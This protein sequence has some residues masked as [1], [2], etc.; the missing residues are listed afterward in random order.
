MSA[1]ITP[2]PTEAQ[3]PDNTKNWRG[4]GLTAYYQFSNKDDTIANQKNAVIHWAHHTPEMWAAFV[5]DA[6]NRLAGDIVHQARSEIRSRLK[7]KNHSRRVFIQA[8]GTQAGTPAILEELDSPVHGAGPSIGRIRAKEA[9]PH[10]FH[11]DDEDG[12]PVHGPSTPFARSAEYMKKVNKRADKTSYTA[13]RRT[14]EQE[15]V[16]AA[17]LASPKFPAAGDDTQVNTILANRDLEAIE[18]QLDMEF[19]PQ[20]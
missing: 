15:L 20:P 14:R 13:K 5:G 6:I 7:S 17:L 2:I 3:D 12:S 10:K 18:A 4:L 11:A 1:R 16:H 9:D 8:A 19:P